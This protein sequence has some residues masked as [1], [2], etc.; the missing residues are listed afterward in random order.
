M[1]IKVARF[2]HPIVDVD[3]PDGSS[4]ED[5]A[6]IVVGPLV[7]GWSVLVN[8]E[9]VE[10]RPLALADA[11]GALFPLEEDLSE[12]VWEREL[13]PYEGGAEV[14][15]TSWLDADADRGWQQWADE[16]DGAVGLPVDPVTPGTPVVEGAM[17]PC[18]IPPCDVQDQIRSVVVQYGLSMGLDVTHISWLSGYSARIDVLDD[19][20]D[21]GSSYVKT[22]E[23]CALGDGFTGYPSE[24][25]TLLRERLIHAVETGELSRSPH[26]DGY[27]QGTGF[28]C[29]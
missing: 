27:Q 9:L 26:H 23:V 22:I 15:E 10:P 19:P 25:I 7:D 4:A 28:F 17:D 6:R 24:W 14:A 1:W 11:D 21:G 20:P 12:V 5:V 8:G 13:L 2:G 3:V 29:G 16:A 18:A